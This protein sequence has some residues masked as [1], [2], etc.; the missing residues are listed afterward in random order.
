MPKTHRNAC[1][2]FQFRLRTILAAIVLLSGYLAWQHRIVAHR[3]AVLATAIANHAVIPV[4]VDRV[5]QAGPLTEATVP[6]IRSLMGDYAIHYAKF[7]GNDADVVAFKEAFPETVPVPHG[8]TD[9]T[10][11]LTNDSDY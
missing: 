5:A 11:G 6:W 8:I 10:Y 9:D 3:R 2:W 4:P 7:Y 1:R